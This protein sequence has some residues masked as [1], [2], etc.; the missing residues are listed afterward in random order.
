MVKLSNLRNIDPKDDTQINDKSKVSNQEMLDIIKK[1]KSFVGDEE[2][3][4]AHKF[5]MPNLQ[6][7]APCLNGLVSVLVK[8]LP[9]CSKSR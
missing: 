6:E 9:Y 7:Q 3:T 4:K 2:V 8:I 5:F 1:F